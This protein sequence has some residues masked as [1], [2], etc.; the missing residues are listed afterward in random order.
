MAFTI[1]PGLFGRKRPEDPSKW[2]DNEL[3][4]WFEKGEWLNGWT[5]KPDES[6][7]RREFARQYFRNR[8]RWDKL[9]IFLR[10][11]DLK[12]IEIKKYELDGTNLYAPVSEY[13]SKNVEDAR[14][15]AHEKYADLQYVISG[16][17]LIGVT[18]LSKIRDIVTPYDPEKDIVF[19]TVKEFRDIP[20]NP[21]KFFIFFPAD[22]HRPGLKD[23]ENIMVK[24]LVAKIKVN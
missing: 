15:E 11:S 17:E 22:I 6:L 23:G 8:E 18:S 4:K 9:F 20:A 5:I 13:M 24:K 7:D 2:T 10:E 16:K 12:N 1:Y 14:F 21:G 19:M 3:N